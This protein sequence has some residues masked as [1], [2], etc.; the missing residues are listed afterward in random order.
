MM[1]NTYSFK[2][3]TRPYLNQHEYFKNDVSALILKSN[4]LCNQFFLLLLI[5]LPFYN[6]I[7]L[8]NVIFNY[9]I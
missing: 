2:K 3:L 7:L 4:I 5:Y 1:L 6:H 9:T 8:V